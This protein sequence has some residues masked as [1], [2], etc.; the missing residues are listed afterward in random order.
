LGASQSSHTRKCAKEYLAMKLVIN[1]ISEG[2]VI[3]V[4]ADSEM[5]DVNANASCDWNGRKEEE[6]NGT[7]P[8]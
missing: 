5:C 2:I 4:D 6:M 7:E 8:L 3:N 1:E